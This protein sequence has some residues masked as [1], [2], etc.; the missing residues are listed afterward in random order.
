MLSRE[1]NLPNSKFAVISNFY[2][3]KFLAYHIVG[4]NV[5][6]K[7]IY[8]FFVKDNVNIQNDKNVPAFAFS[9]LFILIDNKIL[10]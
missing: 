8:Q 4:S 5:P 1:I 2:F 3:V 6:S 9:Q 7:M 10:R